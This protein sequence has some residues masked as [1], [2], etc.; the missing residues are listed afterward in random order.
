MK[1]IKFL[2]SKELKDSRS[3]FEL[4]LPKV[5]DWFLWGMLA[6]IIAGSLWATFGQMDVVVRGAALLQPKQNVSEIVSALTGQVASKRF[7]NGQK[8]KRGDILWTLDNREYKV[9]RSVTL[10]QLERDRKQLNDLVMVGNVLLYPETVLPESAKDARRM[11]ELILTEDQRL[12]LL[13]KQAQRVLDQQLLLP[14]ASRTRSKVQDLETSL[15][16]AKIEW[17]S[18]R[19]SKIQINYE[20]INSLLG[21]I[22]GLERHLAELDQEI[23]SS[24]VRSPLDG[25]VE[26]ITKFNVGDTIVAGMTLVRVVPENARDIKAVITVSSDDIAEIREGMKFRLIFPKLPSSEFGQLLGTIDIVPEDAWLINGSSRV[27]QLEGTLTRLWLE[28]SRGLRVDLKSGM[29]A[30]ARIVIKQKPIWR[31]I[32]EKLDFLE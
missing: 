27:F 29:S 26:E 20:S 3:F 9:D 4:R 24:E 28:N 11:A 7:M 10:Q 31:F 8:I 14:E 5:F 22:E 12:E 2:T 30:D 1:D 25:W 18:Y 17:D 21:S 19:K 6:L 16:I 13:V 32:L 23:L 15:Q